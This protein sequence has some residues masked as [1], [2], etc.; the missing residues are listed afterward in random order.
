M[1]PTCAPLVSERQQGAFKR[2]I[3][4]GDQLDTQQIEAQLD[5]GVLWLTIPVKEGT[6]P[7]SIE[8]R[9]GGTAEPRTLETSTS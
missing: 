8:V 1:T 6:K 2:E 3:Q 7:R 4:L 5:K 9:T